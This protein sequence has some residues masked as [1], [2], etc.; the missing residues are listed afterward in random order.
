MSP[1]LGMS[2]RTVGFPRTKFSIAATYFTHSLCISH[3]HLKT[4]P[5][6][7]CFINLV[8][9]SFRKIQT[10]LVNAHLFVQMSYLDLMKSSDKLLKY[11]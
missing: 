4:I 6:V 3:S 7:L 5:Q 10:Y 2:G 11:F 9:E 1:T 8:L